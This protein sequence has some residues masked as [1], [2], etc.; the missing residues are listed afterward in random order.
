MEYAVTIRFKIPHTALEKMSLIDY[1]RIEGEIKD[2][3]GNT[4]LETRLDK[5]VVDVMK[6]V[7]PDVVE[8]Y[9]LP[10]EK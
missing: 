8:V 1:E 10:N 5:L 4:K 7:V 9:I 3:A 6:K 2:M